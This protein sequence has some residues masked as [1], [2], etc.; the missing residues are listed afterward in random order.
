MAVLHLAAIV[1]GGCTG[2]ALLVCC[3]VEML[4][5]ESIGRLEAFRARGADVRRRDGADGEVVGILM[6]VRGR[7]LRQQL[8]GWLQRRR[9]RQR[10]DT[11]G[12]A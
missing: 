2:E 8:L 3:N 10:A 9:V 6:A 1:G 7:V 11:T 5:S 4:R 12:G